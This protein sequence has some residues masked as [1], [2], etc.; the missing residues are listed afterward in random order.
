[1]RNATATSAGR[2]GAPAKFSARA[3]GMRKA[4]FKLN[5]G[6]SDWLTYFR[7]GIL[8]RLS[9]VAENRTAGIASR[10]SSSTSQPMAGHL[11]VGYQEFEDLTVL[12]ILALACLWITPPTRVNP[13]VSWRGRL[14]FTHEF[15]PSELRSPL[16]P[17]ARP[18]TF[19]SLS[20]STKPYR[21]A[22]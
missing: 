20:T 19:M 2:V 4:S 8:P 10:R 18:G 16:I 1:M 22:P 3:V 5:A 11:F 14:M 6:I 12:R 13:A 7:C 21:R 17:S 9:L 15:A